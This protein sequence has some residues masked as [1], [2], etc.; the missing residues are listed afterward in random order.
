MCRRFDPGPVH[1]AQLRIVPQ[2]VARAEFILALF[3]LPANGQLCDGIALPHDAQACCC[4][5]RRHGTGRDSEA[6]S[7]ALSEMT[8]TAYAAGTGRDNVIMPVDEWGRAMCRRSTGGR[9][10]GGDGIS[11]AGG[12]MRLTITRINRIAD[13]PLRLS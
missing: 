6:R 3:Q 9:H 12:S 11:D 7:R 8:P 5:G 4:A 13:V 1:F 10:R 2:T